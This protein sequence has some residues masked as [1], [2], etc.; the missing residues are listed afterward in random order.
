MAKIIENIDVTVTYNVGLGNIKV[1]DNVYQELM[2]AADEC[3]EVDYQKYPNA[4]EWLRNN[5]KES[6]CCDWDCEMKIYK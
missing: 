3:G 4:A 2:D 6:D 5:I 1:D